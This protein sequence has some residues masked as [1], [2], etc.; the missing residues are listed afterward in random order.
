M[1]LAG[2]GLHAV[3]NPGKVVPIWDCQLQDEGAN[4]IL[5]LLNAA[6]R[7]RDG[8]GDLPKLDR[9]ALRRA[10]IRSGLNPATGEQGYLVIIHTKAS[11][12]WGPPPKSKTSPRRGRAPRGSAS[13]RRLSGTRAYAIESFRGPSLA[14]HACPSHHELV[15]QGGVIHSF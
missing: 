4:H 15:R 6:V 13:Q 10:T 7:T 14:P 12:E 11:L 5:R 3:D 9:G 1:P 2:F 8:G